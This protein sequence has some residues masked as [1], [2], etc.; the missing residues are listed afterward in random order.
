MTQTLFKQMLSTVAAYA[1]KS[2]AAGG[3]VRSLLGMLLV[4]LGTTLSGAA[5]QSAQAVPI[6][7]VYSDPAGYGFNDAALGSQ[8]KT[9]LEAA[10]ANWSQRLKG[11]VPIIISVHFTDQL[12]AGLN[13]A[14][15][16][17][18]HPTLSFANTPGLPLKDTSYP[19]ALANELAGKDV[20]PSSSPTNPAP[21]IDLE[22]NSQIGTGMVLLG[23]QFYYGTDG[24]NG[25]DIDFYSVA[26]HE[27]AHGLGF[28]SN[29]QQN[30]SY[31][32]ANP[33]VFSTFLAAG[34][35]LADK[36]LSAM[37]PAARAAALTSGHLYFVG[38]ETNRAGG[39][40][41]AKLY[42]PDPFAEGNSIEH[43]DE[44]T[45]HGINEMMTPIGVVTGAAETHDPG[46]IATAIL[47]DIGWGQVGMAPALPSISGQVVDGVGN[48]IA[49]VTVSRASSSA[50]TQSVKTGA[51]G[52]Y[53]FTN[54]PSGS[55]Q[56][57]VSLSGASFTPGS[58]GVVVSKD[59]FV[60]MNFERTYTISG[61]IDGWYTDAGRTRFVYPTSVAITCRRSGNAI[62]FAQTVTDARGNFSLNPVP[63]G[64]Y[65]ISAT[66]P[67]LA[68]MP[69]PYNVAITTSDYNAVRFCP[70]VLA[71]EQKGDY[72]HPGIAAYNYF[73]GRVTDT[74]GRGISVKLSHILTSSGRTYN[75]GDIWSDPQGYFFGCNSTWSNESL[76]L[77]PGAPG[78]A[79]TPGSRV[80][81]LFSPRSDL[82]FVATY[83]S[84]LSGKVVDGA[85]HGVD[86]V[87]VSRHSDTGASEDTHTDSSGAYTFNNVAPGTYTIA[88][89]KQDWTFNPDTQSVTMA[90]SNLTV[91]K[92][93]VGSTFYNISGQV[94]S[95]SDPP[96]GISGVK[97]SLYVGDSTQ[98]AQT[99]TSGADGQYSFGHLHAGTYNI[100]AS[101]D[102]RVFAPS[103]HPVTI[104]NAQ[105]D[106]SGQDFIDVTPHAI[107]GQVVDNDGN[108]MVGVTLTLYPDAV[109]PNGPSSSPVP[110]VTT[111]TNGNYSF[112]KVAP[113][114]YI[115]VPTQ[116]GSK[117]DPARHVVKLTSGDVTGQ[118]FKD[119]TTY[120]ISGHVSVDGTGDNVPGVTCTLTKSD[121]TVVATATTGNDG[122]YKITGVYRGTYSVTATKP[123]WTV[124][125]TSQSVTITAG[126]VPDV[127]FSAVGDK[128][129]VTGRVVD[130]DGEGLA[131]VNC[132]AIRSDGVTPPPVVTDA[133]GNYTLAGISPGTYTITP[134]KKGWTFNPPTQTVTGDNTDV[135]DINFKEAT[136]PRFNISG[137]VYT[138]HG[139]AV[140]GAVIELRKH[141]SSTIV[142]KATS[143]N[144]G[145]YILPAVRQGDYDLTATKSGLSFDPASVKVTV[146]DANLVAMNF[147]LTTTFQVSGR[148]VDSK[149]DG[150]GGATVKLYQYSPVPVAQVTTD[151]KGN[152]T[153]TKVP[154]G[155]CSIVASRAGFKFTP[156]S[157]ANFTLLTDDVKTGNF[158]GKPAYAIGGRI[159]TAAGAAVSEVTVTLSSTTS[160]LSR[161]TTTDTKGNYSFGD[162]TINDLFEVGKYIV[163]PSLK[164]TT[165]T[166]ASR[167]VTLTNANVTDANFT[168]SDP[169]PPPT[170]TISGKV[171]TPGGAASEG[172]A[173]VTLTLSSTTSSKT[174]TTTTDSKGNYTFGAVA[175]D[176]LVAG[177]YTVTASLKGRI[178]APTSTPVSVT[179]ANVKD[180]NFVINEVNPTISGHVTYKGKGI[181]GIPVACAIDGGRIIQ[182][183]YT[184]ATG[185]YT[186]HNL[187]SAEYFVY[188]DIGVTD[189]YG[190][191]TG[192]WSPAGLDVMLTTQSLSGLDFSEY[193]GSLPSGVTI[194]G[195]VKGIS[196]AI[197][198]KRLGNLRYKAMLTLRKVGSSS[199]FASTVVEYPADPYF[200]SGSYHLDNIPPGNYD[201]TFT[202]AGLAADEIDVYN[203]P[204]NA[205]TYPAYSPLAEGLTVRISV[206]TK[207]VEIDYQEVLARN[208]FGNAVA[209]AS[210]ST[211]NVAKSSITLS[212]A[213]VE[214]AT[215][216]VGLRFMSALDAATAS[217][218][219]HYSV[220]VN[221]RS[222][223]VESAGYNAST[224]SVTL[225]LPESSLHAGDHVLAGW[226]DL[227]DAKGDTLAGST[228]PLTAR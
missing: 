211:S 196:S 77:T 124:T 36:H 114:S 38:P 23:Q 67:G 213:K 57:T 26:M 109:Y 97:L 62:I 54:V 132:T 27:I 101:K 130:R 103:E 138:V 143:D 92:N 225:S 207:T 189:G 19:Y 87:L 76:T 218:P 142:Q 195:V 46:P 209:K 65:D 105:G 199:I 125:P 127:N 193:D 24:K 100:L 2:R 204:N 126:D 7:V 146:A 70:P 117:F 128:F 34:P 25:S 13:S 61:H 116:D 106:V 122:N 15:L 224:H 47:M 149:G 45:Y 222:V 217:D 80:F 31:S 163:T 220:T 68:F 1:T 115:I 131:G 4:V 202:R 58:R 165:F 172:V 41:G 154:S 216:L 167:P 194:Q 10:A 107:S 133:N 140:S 12:P 134:T 185:A 104:T 35:S 56:I 173:G 175:T 135:T 55:Y 182:T 169:P 186:F 14:V 84:S 158:V 152:Y 43:L 123:E 184:D 93:F 29:L 180:I 75:E 90:L 69:S 82:N 179:N 215:G 78:L 40:S 214:A 161:T 210:V 160:R 145:S 73:V 219:T 108:P 171:T 49:G 21:E 174:W 59:N 187:P 156:P 170:Y 8:R 5:L 64:N 37:T 155:T 176:N 71:P 153:F 136:A 188:P 190:H 200:G 223:N 96:S 66:K 162:E 228:S 118:N 88:V 33:D 11:T 177:D 48:G 83:T 74:A 164:N 102:G 147:V 3:Q 89:A 206:T 120:S 30:G 192:G 201:L 81:N 151:S 51:D 18:G 28:A 20:N 119:N 139:G 197:S 159:T 221:G 22:F 113:G 39:G 98:P 16:A 111:D 226:H 227:Q 121:G 50:P 95:E 208:I 203:P 150:I 148:V 94:L 205:I 9:A 110:P 63:G 42:A 79:F 181:E 53:S 91:P 157:D 129:N 32:S 99:I 144:G 52:T 86:N 183:V 112:P 178:F 60:N 141:G 198:G 6:K 191:S 17:V 168:A 137:S 166:P 85:G 212:T 44:D 72:R